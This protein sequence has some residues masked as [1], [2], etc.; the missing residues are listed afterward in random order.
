MMKAAGGKTVVHC[1]V[2]VPYTRRTNED[3]HRH[4]KAALEAANDFLNLKM[5]F[6][7]ISADGRIYT[8]EEFA[9]TIEGCASDERYHE[10][11]RMK[12]E[13]SGQSCK[14]WKKW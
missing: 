5:P 13:W 10:D 8:A 1:T 2:P 6:V 11:R 12:Y 14:N 4:A 3:H 9:N 7:T